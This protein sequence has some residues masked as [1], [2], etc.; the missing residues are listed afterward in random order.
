MMPPNGL[1]LLAAGEASGK[2]PGMLGVVAN[3]AGL[4]LE[5]QA[6]RLAIKLNSF[7]VVMTG[8]I[9]GAVVFT[10]MGII[11]T[12]FDSIAAAGAAANAVQTLS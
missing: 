12:T 6:E 7:A 3:E 4:D 9:V 5:T 10:L 11:S 8:L 2:L 1:A